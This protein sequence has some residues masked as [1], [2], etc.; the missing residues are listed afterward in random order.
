M[1]MKMK[2]ILGALALVL[3]LSISDGKICIEL[4]SKESICVYV[5]TDLTGK[6][7]VNMPVSQHLTHIKIR[8][9]LTMISVNEENN[10]FN[11]L[12]SSNKIQLKC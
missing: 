11:N 2:Q 4:I 12:V 7:S 3:L 9:L 6:V 8:S 1:A 10:D 5:F